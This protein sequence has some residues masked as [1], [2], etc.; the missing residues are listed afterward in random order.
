[1]LAATD[2]GYCVLIEVKAV[3]DMPLAITQAKAA[4]ARTF[5]ARR[6]WGYLLT[7]DCGQT[8]HDLE[9]LPVPEQA[10]QAFADALHEAGTMAWRDIKAYRERHG[11]N[12]L[13]VA[14]LAI[15]RRWCIRLDPYR[16]SE[17]P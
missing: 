10:A 4:A 12:P 2:D 1:M 11:L 6:G 17:H 5:C 15:Q 3:P 9:T 14:A 8:L 13:Q 16:M 7:T